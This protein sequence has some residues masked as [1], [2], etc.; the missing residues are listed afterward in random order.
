MKASCHCGAWWVQRGNQTGHCGGCHKTFSSLA[1]FDAHRRDGYCLTADA[2]LSAV[3]KSGE[4]LFVRQTGGG[5]SSDGML[6]ALARTEKQ[7]AAL[8]ALKQKRKKEA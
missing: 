8:A 6:W 2:M 7:Q 1:A 5:H 4:P 3:R